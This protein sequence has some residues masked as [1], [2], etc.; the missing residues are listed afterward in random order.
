MLKLK[1]KKKKLILKKNKKKL[2]SLKSKN[3]Q[4]LFIYLHKFET[5]K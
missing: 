1:L 4:T 3:Q 2:E 5:E